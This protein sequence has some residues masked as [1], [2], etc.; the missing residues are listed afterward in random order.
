[1]KN[2]LATLL[3]CSIFFIIATATSY[4]DDIMQLPFAELHLDVEVEDSFLFISNI[5]TLDINGAFLNFAT[6]SNDSITGDTIRWANYIRN[7]YEL[8][9]GLSDTLLFSSFIHFE[10]STNLSNEA[11]PR[12]FSL[13]FSP[14][15]NAILYFSKEF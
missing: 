15:E 7:D 3:T 8:E 4:D 9:M 12:F 10:D 13:Q 6:V 2:L 14:D 1:M 5:D 11:L